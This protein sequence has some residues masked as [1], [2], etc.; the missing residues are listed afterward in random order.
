MFE[1]WYILKF[2]YVSP[3]GSETQTK[4]KGYE[5]LTESKRIFEQLEL[6]YLFNVPMRVKEHETIRVTGAWLY[7]SYKFKFEDAVDDVNSGNA[8]LMCKAQ[9]IE[10]DLED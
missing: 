1:V 3:P 8:T 4:I 7:E 5:H 9:G 6:S 10:I 2:D